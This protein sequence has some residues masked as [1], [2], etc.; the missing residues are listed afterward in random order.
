MT[1]KLRAHVVIHTSF[2][3]PPIPIR[4]CDWHACFD[5]YD[6][7]PDAGYQC[8]GDGGTE[9]KAVIALYDEWEGWYGEEGDPIPNPLCAHRPMFVEDLA[10]VEFERYAVMG[11]YAK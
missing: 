7:S 10:D 4:S 1:T 8:G 3:Y 11:L 6:S 9:L 5:D 2:V